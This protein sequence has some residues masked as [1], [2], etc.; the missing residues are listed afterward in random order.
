MGYAK[1]GTGG[2]NKIFWVLRTVETLEP[3][4]M[5]KN[6]KKTAKIDKK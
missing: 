5:T 6:V 1:G 2:E 4:K 3:E